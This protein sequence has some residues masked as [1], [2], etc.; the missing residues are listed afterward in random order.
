MVNYIAIEMR[1][2]P[3]G[4]PKAHNFFIRYTGQGSYFLFKFNLHCGNISIYK[5]QKLLDIGEEL[6]FL[7]KG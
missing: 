6:D 1:R 5:L 2:I 3:A 4:Y 7:Q